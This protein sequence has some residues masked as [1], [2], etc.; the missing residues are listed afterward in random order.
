MVEFWRHVGSSPTIPAKPL[1]HKKDS[2]YMEFEIYS[3]RFNILNS[4]CKLYL[5]GLDEEK[6]I[7]LTR[8]I[9]SQSSSTMSTL[10]EFANQSR[11]TMSTLIEFA[12]WDLRKSTL[13]PIHHAVIR[14]TII[15]YILKTYPKQDRFP[16]QLILSIVQKH[17][18]MSFLGK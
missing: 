8:F 15:D 1:K 4:E 16:F 5:Y 14:E 9:I 2:W 12:N 17:I 3:G 7:T 13:G 11:Y 6:F 18:L 10:M